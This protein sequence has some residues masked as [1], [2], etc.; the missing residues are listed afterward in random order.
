MNLRK[1]I[2]Q[3]YDQIHV[4]EEVSERLKQK[5]YQRDFPEDPETETEEWTP[6]RHRTDWGLVSAVAVLCIVVGV[7][8]WSLFQNRNDT[9]FH[10]GSAVPAEISTTETTE[11]STEPQES[12]HRN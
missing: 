6:V 5:L 7:S 12:F 9:N 8:A 11:E 2:K 3:T 4:P 1:E 10:P